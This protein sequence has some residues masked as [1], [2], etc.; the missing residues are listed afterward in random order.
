[1]QIAICAIVK[2]KGGKWEVLHAFG[3]LEYVRGI[4]Q[5]K[6]HC[7]MFCDCQQENVGAGLSLIPQKLS[8]TW[9]FIT[10]NQIIGHVSVQAAFW[11]ASNSFM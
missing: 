2:E 11:F 6:L 3:A 7:N 4:L 5:R 10:S 1:M 9:A 8:K